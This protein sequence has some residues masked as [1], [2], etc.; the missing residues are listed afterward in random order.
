MMSAVTTQKRKG[1]L[2]GFEGEEAGKWRFKRKEKCPKQM[3]ICVQFRDIVQLRITRRPAVQLISYHFA[4]FSR[5]DTSHVKL[6][7]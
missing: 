4:I 6:V 3:K 7:T 1:N 2:N 5:Q